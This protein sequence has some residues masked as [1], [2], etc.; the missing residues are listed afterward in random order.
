MVVEDSWVT[1]VFP[2]TGQR[3]GA[4][5]V[6]LAVGT[7]AQITNLIVADKRATD[8]PF[9]EKTNSS[10]VGWTC[11]DFIQW[12]PEA[13]VGGALRGSDDLG[14]SFGVEHNLDIAIH[15]LK[16]FSPRLSE[17]LSREFGDRFP[18]NDYKKGASIISSQTNAH[19][20]RVSPPGSLDTVNC[21]FTV[22]E[23][24]AADGDQYWHH[25]VS[26]RFTA[27]SSDFSEKAKAI[28]LVDGNAFLNWLGGRTSRWFLRAVFV[29]SPRRLI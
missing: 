29:S 25:T 8:L 20:M 15:S 13:S 18:W 28:H 17:T 3:T 7:A 10:S 9:T 1:L 6:R 22:A 21:R 2:L 12:P 5:R 11:L 14:T 19:P 16:D 27:R 24:T 23:T 26:H 4:L